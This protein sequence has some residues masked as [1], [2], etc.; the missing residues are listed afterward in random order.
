[1][2]RG[3]KMTVQAKHRRRTRRERPHEQFTVAIAIL[4]LVIAG[5]MAAGA[6]T[7]TFRPDTGSGTPGSAAP[8]PET[9]LPPGDPSDTTRLAHLARITGEISP[10]SV[11]ASPAGS[12]SANNMMYSHS[13]TLYDAERL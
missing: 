13:S 2:G 10:K 4:S 11:V 5:G 3:Q 1:M 12:V 7:I 6:A 9:Q 8:G